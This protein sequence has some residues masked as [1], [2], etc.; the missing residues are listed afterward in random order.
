MMT[1]TK[2]NDVGRSETI[3]SPKQWC[4]V[5]QKIPWNGLS[6]EQATYHCLL[7]WWQ[8]SVKPYGVNMRAY[9]WLNHTSPGSQ[10]KVHLAVCNHC[11]LHRGHRICT[12]SIVS[13]KK[14]S[15]LYLYHWK[16]R[17]IMMSEG[18]VSLRS[19]SSQLQDIV[20]HIQRWKLIKCIFCSVWVQSIVWN[21]NGVL[22]NFTHKY[23]NPYTATCAFYEC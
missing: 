17:V 22:W 18:D 9:I 6:A 7:E 5:V 19:V 14:S 11:W 8:N 10:E 3:N 23:S 20:S 2:I 13:Q 1:N 15:L 12:H 4:F 16:L 21:F